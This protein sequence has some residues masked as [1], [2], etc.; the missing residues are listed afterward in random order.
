[1]MAPGD[2]PPVCAACGVETGK[3]LTCARCRSVWYCSADC[4]R[5]HWKK[6][7]KRECGKATASAKP[8]SAQDGDLEDGSECAICMETRVEPVQLPCL[9]SFCGGCVESLK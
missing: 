3:L 4:Q 6:V 2:T 8:P 5:A 1:M 9:H 7:H